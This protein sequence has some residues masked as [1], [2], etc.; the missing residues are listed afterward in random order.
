MDFHA[1]VRAC[2]D[3]RGFRWCGFVL[4]P[5]PPFTFG[6]FVIIVGGER[7]GGAPPS[8][9]GRCVMYGPPPSYVALTCRDKCGIDID[10][11]A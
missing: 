8:H 9:T 2:A 3:T 5:S 6:G 10:A 7:E 1:Y 4:A 11:H